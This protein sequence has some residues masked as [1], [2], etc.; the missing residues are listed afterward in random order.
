VDRKTSRKLLS[1]GLITG[2]GIAVVFALTFLFSTFYLA[3]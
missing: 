1:S 2:T 3:S